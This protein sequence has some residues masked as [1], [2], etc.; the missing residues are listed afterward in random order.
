MPP[1]P[2]RTRVP[3]RSGGSAATPP[4]GAIRTRIGPRSS[5]TRGS[6]SSSAR[7][8]AVA[9]GVQGV[10]GVGPL[11]GGRQATGERRVSRSRPMAGNAC[12]SRRAP[13][14]R[15]RRL[16]DRARSTAVRTGERARV[17]P[18]ATTVSR[19]GPGPPG[20]APVPCA[21]R[22]RRRRRAGRAERTGHARRARPRRPGR[23]A[24]R[25]GL[26][27]PPRRGTAWAPGSRAPRGGGRGA[28]H[29]AGR[30]PIRGRSPRSGPPRRPPPGSRSSARA[31]G[32]A[33][34]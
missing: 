18:V 25:R 8:R 23:A 26:S 14:A 7:D 15:A 33:R 21:G 4:T 34:P 22:S 3:G 19:S 28:P 13:A 16:E 5:L 20:P 1:A 29:S 32:A 10:Q 9:L 27:G 30:A 6:W 31:P 17:D 2:F 11:G 12:G 24:A